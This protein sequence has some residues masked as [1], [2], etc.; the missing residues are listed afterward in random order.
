MMKPTQPSLVLGDAVWIETRDGDPTVEALFSRHY[1]AAKYRA[2]RA[3]ALFCGPG[4]KLVL[5]TPCARAMFIWRKFISDDGQEGVNCA[6]F[7]N[8]G[9][10]LS[11]A[12][13]EAAMALAWA[14]WPGER[15]YTYVW[16]KK[17]A[18]P[19]PGYCFL[20]AGW[21]RCGTTKTRKML[22]L[23]C[24]PDWVTPPAP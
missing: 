10:G 21:R 18:S 13:I 6:A 11:S 12:L 23:E 3:P 7:R 9:A 19:N 1:S 20:R 8:E 24:R 15:F 4:E 17:V 5:K 16:A 2:V 22:I 14:R